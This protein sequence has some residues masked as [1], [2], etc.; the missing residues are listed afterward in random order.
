MRPKFITAALVVVAGFLLILPP[1]YLLNSEARSPSDEPVRVLEQYLKRL[2]ARDFSQAYRLI[3]A[4]DQKLKAAKTYVRERGPF[5]GF[6]SEVA[7]KLADLIEVEPMHQRIDGDRLHIELA[8]KLPDATK[9]APLLLNWD[10]EA[11]NALPS[12][13]KRKILAALENQRRAGKLKMIEGEEEFTLIKERNQ[14]KILLDWA[15]GVRVSFAT[16][17]DGFPELEARAV[18]KETVTRP[19]DLFSIS[20]KVK[21]HSHEDLFARIVHYVEPRAVAEY[22]DIVECALLL[23]VRVL[24]GEEQEYA[25]TYLLKADL[26]DGTKELKVTYEFKVVR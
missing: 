18:T 5:T 1:V 19:N 7:S 26:P 4:R 12:F 23:P 21:N 8:M 9:V 13:E 16:Q 3:S 10:E 6:A 20:Y 14:W 11:L 22:L 25:S 15:S 17:V 24:P 2:Y